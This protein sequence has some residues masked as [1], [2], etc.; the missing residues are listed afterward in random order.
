MDPGVAKKILAPLNSKAKKGGGGVS[1][2]MIN[3][4]LEAHEAEALRSG[5]FGEL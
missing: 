5:P 1:Y 4:A 2:E 3:A